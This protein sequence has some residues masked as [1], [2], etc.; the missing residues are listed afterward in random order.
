ML[1]TF[2]KSKTNKDQRKKVNLPSK[3]A[4][5]EVP[6]SYLKKEKGTLITF[7][8][9]KKKRSKEKILT[10]VTAPKE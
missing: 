1:V 10:G 4:H 8:K 9:V 7:P 5:F 6:K 2:P 3:I